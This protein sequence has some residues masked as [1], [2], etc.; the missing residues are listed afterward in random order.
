M[1]R[2]DKRRKSSTAKNKVRRKKTKPVKDNPE[3][4]SQLK[5]IV[6]KSESED[7]LQKTTGLTQ[8]DNI[9]EQ[10]YERKKQLDKNNINAQNHAEQMKLSMDDAGDNKKESLLRKL[11][12]KCKYFIDKMTAFFKGI[13]SKIIKWIETIQNVKNKV[14]MISDFIHEEINREGLK[15]TLNSLKKLLKHIKPTKLRS[16]II[17]GTGDPCSTGQALGVLGFLYSF[18]GDNIQIIPDFENERLEGKHYARGRIR[19]VT[20]LIIVIK[21][22][23]NKKFKQLKSNFQILREAL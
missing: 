21:L 5:D 15:V 8:T 12:R 2:A 3:K 13:K 1:K 17:F 7:R 9:Q 10:E 14:N 11:I 20:I 18:Y 19:L 22:I 4:E 23:L 16:R 6:P